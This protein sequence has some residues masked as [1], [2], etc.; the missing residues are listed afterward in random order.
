MNGH[1]TKSITVRPDHR[2]KWG[3]SR[4]VFEYGLAALERAGLVKVERVPGRPSQIT[5]VV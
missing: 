3:L 1:Q 4:R 5:L 2:E